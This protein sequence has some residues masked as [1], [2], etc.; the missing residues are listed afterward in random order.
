MAETVVDGK[1]E[2]LLRLEERVG[3]MPGAAARPK[4]LVE[5]GAALDHKV[6][7]AGTVVARNTGELLWL[8]PA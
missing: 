6:A 1:V 3:G 5:D 2:R 7:A 4:P 8:A